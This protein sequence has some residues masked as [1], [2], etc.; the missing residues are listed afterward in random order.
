MFWQQ[1]L[2][3]PAPLVS[4]CEQAVS[5][6]IARPGY[7]LSNIPYIV[8]GIWLLSKKDRT[9]RI[10]GLASLIIGSMSM[11]YDVTFT[12]GAQFFD[13]MGM[14]F[15]I[16]T[17]L[18]LNFG[19]LFPKLNRRYISA[20]LIAL[21]IVEGILTLLARG[22]SLEAIWTINI[23]AIIATELYTWHKSQPKYSLKLWLFGL[24]LYAV[25][26]AIWLLD[27]YKVYC[28]PTNLFNGRGVF[29][30]IT[31]I[32]LYLLYRHYRDLNIKF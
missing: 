7:A 2:N 11:L 21:Y 31:T 24:G 13:Q 12:F 1:L 20:G 3:S 22:D 16:S 4:Y 17:I 19:R 10:F 5:G 28:D 25:G 29:H 18:Y 23:L 8:L 32:V 30:Y 26:Q 15:F 14:L 6:I 27:A 9:A